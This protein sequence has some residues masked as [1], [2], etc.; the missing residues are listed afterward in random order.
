MVAGSGVGVRGALW[1]P[2]LVLACEVLV[3]AGSGVG[4]RGALWW[5]VL[6]LACE[7]LCGGR[8]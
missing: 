8:F 4:V 2:V 7:A 5:P 1:W 6:V 3:V